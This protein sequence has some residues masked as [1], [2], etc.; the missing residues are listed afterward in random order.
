[1]SAKLNAYRCTEC[2]F[3]FVVVSLNKNQMGTASPYCPECGSDEYTSK[4]E[5]V[6]LSLSERERQYEIEKSLKP[7]P[8]V[9]PSTNV[10]TYTPSAIYNDA[11]ILVDPKWHDSFLKFVETGE[12]SKDFLA[13]VDAS[14]KAQKAVEMIFRH[15]SEAMRKFSLALSKK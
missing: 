7:I 3:E 5:C 2:D 10:T 14:E 4:I 12:A 8:G 9:P 11:L 13:Y 15:Q 1:M 6:T